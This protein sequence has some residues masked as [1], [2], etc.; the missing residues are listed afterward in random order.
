MSPVILLSICIIYLFEF[1]AKIDGF[2][3]QFGYQHPA[4]VPIHEVEI[5]WKSGVYYMD[6][7]D[8]AKQF[9]FR[10]NLIL[11]FDESQLGSGV[12]T[13]IMRGGIG[14]NFTTLR[15]R[16]FYSD[17]SK[18]KSAKVTVLI[19]GLEESHV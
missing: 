16:S 7:V 14:F 10:I 19:Y 6:F 3:I 11:V 5:R 4:A 13:E 8:N 1:V 18:V 9:N 12:L 17:G 15:L 2:S